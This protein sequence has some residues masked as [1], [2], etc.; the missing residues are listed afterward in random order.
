MMRSF[1]L[2]EADA[3]APTPIGAP[4]GIH[5]ASSRAGSDRQKPSLET[6]WS[7]ARSAVVSQPSTHP[8]PT[9]PSRAAGVGRCPREARCPCRVPLGCSREDGWGCPWS[10]GS[11]RLLAASLHRRWRA[12]VCVCV[13]GGP[14]SGVPVSWSPSGHVLATCLCR[15]ACPDRV[16][17]LRGPKGIPSWGV[18]ACESGVH[19]AEWSVLRPCPCPCPCPCLWLCRG[20]GGCAACGAVWCGVV[21]CGAVEPAHHW[22]Q[23]RPQGG[24][25]CV[26]LR[27]ARERS[28][29]PQRGRWGS[30]ALSS[31]IECDAVPGDAHHGSS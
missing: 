15:L 3:S 21:R 12:R 2:D 24:L 28:A 8:T 22:M 27:A 25:R 13:W 10:R 7:R 14:T 4:L 1:F 23:L 29:G 31:V 17:P 19:P 11:A 6:C 9:P 30:A 26:V 16:D 18:G 20:C 5:T